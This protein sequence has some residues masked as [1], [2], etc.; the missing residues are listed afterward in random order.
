MLWRHD[1]FP[2]AHTQQTGVYWPSVMESSGYHPRQVCPCWRG[3]GGGPHSDGKYVQWAPLCPSSVCY[4]TWFLHTFIQEVTILCLGVLTKGTAD[5]LAQVD[6]HLCEPM[7][8]CVQEPPLR[9]SCGYPSVH[10]SGGEVPLP[11]WGSP[12]LQCV[13]ISAHKPPPW[14]G[15]THPSLWLQEK[16]P[17]LTKTP[18]CRMQVKL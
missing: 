5:V 16:T 8:R 1:V 9:V 18:P 6:G 10:E 3:R 14:Q 7:G 17:S 2:S 4:K 15:Q 12:V 13:G 11:H